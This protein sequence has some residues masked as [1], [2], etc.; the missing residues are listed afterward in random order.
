MTP[1]TRNQGALICGGAGLAALLFLLGILQG[2]YWALAI[3]VAILVFAVVVGG[4]A[5]GG[6]ALQIDAGLP[7]ASINILLALLLLAVLGRRGRT[8]GAEG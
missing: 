4:I 5:V 3:P 8:R 6:D 2:S 7:A 1:N